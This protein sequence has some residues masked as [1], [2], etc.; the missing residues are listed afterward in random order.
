MNRPSLSLPP[1]AVQLPEN[2]PG[3]AF[4]QVAPSMRRLPAAV[5]HPLVSVS[6]RVSPYDTKVLLDTFV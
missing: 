1:R 2:F 3:A 4:V 5:Y 6:T